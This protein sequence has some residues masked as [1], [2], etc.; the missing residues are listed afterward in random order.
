ML[1]AMPRTTGAGHR[2][3]KCTR[4][5]DG[6]FSP[7]RPMRRDRYQRRFS[8]AFAQYGGWGWSASLTGT[9]LAGLIIMPGQLLQVYFLPREPWR[10]VGMASFVPTMRSVSG[11]MP[12]ATIRVLRGTRY[13]RAILP[14]VSPLATTWTAGSDNKVCLDGAAAVGN[15][16]AA[17][18]AIAAA[19]AL[20]WPGAIGPGPVLAFAFVMVGTGIPYFRALMASFCPTMIRVIPCLSQLDDTSLTPIV[21]VTST[22]LEGSSFD[23]T[24]E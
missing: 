12:F 11:W 5:G 23:T 15:G 16:T 18:V 19:S 8:G 2:S 3:A 21:P 7:P 14:N 24:L 13:L 10:P 17:A 22:A 9:V 20:R 4:D 6:G 1:G